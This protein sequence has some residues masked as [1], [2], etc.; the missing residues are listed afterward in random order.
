MCK[1][2]ALCYTF[3]FRLANFSIKLLLYS[4]YHKMIIALML[5]LQSSNFCCINIFY[6]FMIISIESYWPLLI[7]IYTFPTIFGVVMMCVC[8]S[9]F[10]PDTNTG[11]ILTLNMHLHCWGRIRWGKY[12][13]LTSFG[14][15]RLTQPY[16][17]LTQISFFF[18][19]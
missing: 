18:L 3:S 14:L 16:P 8:F 5:I 2:T 10:H 12:I 11:Q 7:T 15:Q 17:H 9:L 4:F 19:L 13:K 1:L 6:A